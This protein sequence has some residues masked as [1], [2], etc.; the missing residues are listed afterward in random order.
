[1]VGDDLTKIV[2]KRH[3]HVVDC[4]DDV[5]LAQPSY[6]GWSVADNSSDPDSVVVGSG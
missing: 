3:G 4:F 6:I 5:A 1:M 2:E